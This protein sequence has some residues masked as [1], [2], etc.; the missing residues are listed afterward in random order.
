MRDSLSNRS[1]AGRTSPVRSLLLVVVL[2][3]A[4]ASLVLLDR[5]GRLEPFRSQAQGVLN[6]VLGTL[7]NAGDQLGGVGRG[8]SNVQDLRARNDELERQLSEYRDAFL[9]TQSLKLKVEQL[10]KQL[11]IEQATPWKLLPVGVVAVTPDVGRHVMLIS[12]GQEDGVEVGMA[13]IGQEGGSPTAL[14]GVVEQVG[15]RS[16][17]VLLISDFS[18]EISAKVFHEGVVADGVVQGQFQRGGWLRLE[19]VDRAV[20]LGQRDQVVTAGLTAKMDL[21]LPHSAIPRNIPIGVVDRAWT[22]GYRQFAELRPYLAP[23]QVRYAWVILSHD[24]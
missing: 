9:E 11:E 23:D 20:P 7:Q 19:E 6:P 24:D 10:Q 5:S 8:L 13:V 21:D 16:A 15:P 3:V 2:V 14:V 17:S 4:A 12:Q 1:R 18:S 22:E